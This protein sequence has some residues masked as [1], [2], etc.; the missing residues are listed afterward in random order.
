MR[1]FASVV[2]ILAIAGAWS[3]RG[4]EPTRYVSHPPQRPLPQAAN[5]V[6]AAGSALF[7]DGAKGDDGGDG[8]KDKPWKTLAFAV[9]Q[10]KP[11]DTLLLRDG[12]HRGH[13]KATL[14]GTGEKP[15]T[16]GGYP[17]ELAILD[18]GIADFYDA[19]EAAWEPCPGG[20]SGEFW[21]TKTYPDLG[22]RADGTNVLGNFADSM[23]PLHGYRLRGDLQSDNPYWNVENKVGSES[24]VYC[25]PGIFYD[26]MTG[27]IHCR[28]AHTK[29]PGLHEDNYRGETDPRKLKLIVAGHAG[30]P[31]LELIDS[32]HVRLFDLVLRGSREATL[33][34]DESQAIQ[35]SGAT[36]YGGSTPVLVEN[37]QQFGMTNTACRGLAA[38]W[39]FRGSLKYRAIESRL[40]STGGWAPTGND[41][42]KL[43]FVNCEFTDSV[44]GVFLGNAYDVH[45]ESNLLDNVSDDGI[46]L[47]ANT[48]YDGVT[49]GGFVHICGNR[50]SR[51][52]TT[53][54]FGVGHGRQKVTAA[55][56]Q[57]GSGVRIYRN[58]FDF[59][60]PVMYHWPTGPDAPQEITSLG[61]FAGDHGSPA[62]EP[63]WIYHNTILAGDPPRYDYGTDGLGR[64]VVTGTKRRVFNNIV[65]QLQGMVGQTLPPAAADFQA[66]G[67]LFWSISDG[68]K[69]SGELFAK[70]RK[71]PDFA[72]SKA[73]YE[74]GWTA[75]DQFA[76]P[77]FERWESDWRKSPD[78]RLAKGSPA[79]DS[80][81]P[82]PKEFLDMTM[83]SHRDPGPPDLGAVPYGTQPWGVGVMGRVSLFGEEVAEPMPSGT[84]LSLSGPKVFVGHEDFPA[85]GSIKPALIV[86][87]Y[88]AFDAPL[89]EFALRRQHV[90]V[91]VTEK[92]WIPAENFRGYQ[93]VV[94]DGSL[95]RAQISPTQFSPDDLTALK[96]YLEAGGRLL[97]MRERTDLFAS[98]HGRTFL[99]GLTGEG[100]REPGA[101]VSVQLPEHPWVK[102]LAS[103][104]E[105][106]WLSERKASP[107]ATSRGQVILGTSNGTAALYHLPVGKGALVYV[108]WSPAASIPHGRLQST[109]EMEEAFEEQMQIVTKIVGDLA[110][111]P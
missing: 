86:C 88:P 109:V 108:G 92:A 95:A 103:A 37:S 11:G 25:G 67:N 101:Q 7:V 2:S 15:I 64:A 36:I 1:H 81:I 61:R 58:V 60:R 38:P 111:K 68:A 39:T 65:C 104:N 73:M 23:I 56:K 59:R 76:D 70:F 83:T 13:V 3:A 19:P 34:I 17:G 9:T 62:W 41:C 52:L 51:C 31:V 49:R 4:A 87:G 98:P 24:F 82:L 18:G 40:F 91:E 50:L 110:G 6:Y 30:G 14:R 53:F 21:S 89:V 42:R 79:I 66:D 90:P 16:I 54:A 106:P 57:V 99:A 20:V 100:K 75:S 77:R 96:A 44:D 29:L 26:V 105:L 35:V 84:H 94:Y 102:H 72:N 63:M 46:F 33:A 12:I 107:L 93:L 74:P 45:F 5:R 55:G 71:S 10:L 22:G 97:L 69:F 8:S 48:G 80:G 43:R 32:E 85:P 27:R 28:L 78:L 47:T